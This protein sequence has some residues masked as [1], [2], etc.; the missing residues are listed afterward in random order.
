PP[1]PG[2][3]VMPPRPYV[4]A[5]DEI[6]RMLGE[7]SAYVHEGRHGVNNLSTKFD[8]LALDIAKRVE[9]MKSEISLRLDSMD[10]RLTALETAASE[11]K[12]A[13]NLASWF[14]QSPLF[15]WLAAAA[16]VAWSWMKDSP[17]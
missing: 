3:A 5:L 12:G 10:D 13:R 17:R 6:S 15:A 14:V 9:I 2:D 7:L 1:F 11:N 16:V 4:G 8:A